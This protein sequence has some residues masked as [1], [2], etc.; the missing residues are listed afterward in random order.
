MKAVNNTG[1]SKS[2]KGGKGG[3]LR[4]SMYMLL[5]MAMVL[6]V[7]ASAEWKVQDGKLREIGAH[8]YEEGK[9]GEKQGKYPT[10][11]VEFESKDAKIDQASVLGLGPRLSA[12]EL[13]IDKRCKAP[14]SPGN[15][16]ALKEAS[17]LLSKLSAP[18]AQ[19]LQ[20]RRVQVCKEIVETQQ[21]QFKYNLVMSELA[22]QRYERLKEI[23]RHREG[24]KNDEAGKLE[25]NNNRMLALIAAI[26]IDQQQRAAYNDLYEARLA[27]LEG[28][29]ERLT[30]MALDGDGEKS[31]L[32][33]AGDAVG[34]AA[35]A[36]A[37]DVK[38][39]DIVP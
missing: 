31:L 10:P 24:I 34:Y 2:G 19:G 20:A 5:G 1:K 23:R 26:Q 7:A 4:D 27:Y 9:D 15:S 37:L 35:L 6:S 30:Q 18:G 21:A 29:Q 32:D 3:L 39:K 38:P 36:A 14:P 25:E 16:K 8:D 17:D 22:E 33:M 12:V 13:D 11:E 28:L